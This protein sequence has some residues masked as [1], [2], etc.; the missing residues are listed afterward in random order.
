MLQ[1]KLNNEESSSGVRNT[2]ILGTVR[3]MIRTIYGYAQ[4]M[5]T[6]VHLYVRINQELT[7]ANFYPF[8]QFDENGKIYTMDNLHEVNIAKD[9][10]TEL[11]FNFDDERKKSLHQY[12]GQD[13]FGKIIPGLKRAQTAVPQEMRVSYAVAESLM[14][15]EVSY[16]ENISETVAE[17]A[18]EFHNDLLN[19]DGKISTNTYD[20]TELLGEDFMLDLYDDDNDDERLN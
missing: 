11:D 10:G 8:F 3:G 12:L 2:S 15:C 1:V 6:H 7:Q 13:L 5:P 9:D 20:F 4:D 16:K 14:N 17:S 18:Q 19:A